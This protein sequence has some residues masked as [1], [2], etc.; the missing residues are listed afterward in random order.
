MRQALQLDR[1]SRSL[2]YGLIALGLGAWLGC[3][4]PRSIAPSGLAPVPADSARAWAAPLTPTRSLRYRLRWRF[5]NQKGSSGGRAAVRIAPP[6]TLR[7]DYRGPFGKSGSAVVIGDSLLW[8]EPAEDVDRLVGA[9][10]LFWAALGVPVQPSGPEHQVLGRRWSSHVAWRYVDGEEELDFIYTPRGGGRL[11]AELRRGGRI[12]GGTDV[13]F[14][15]DGTPTTA[16]MRFP[17]DASRFSFTVEA[18]DTVAAFDPDTW[19]RS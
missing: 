5:V 7:F 12:I 6:D 1:L 15:P 13:R 8:A 3:T 4:G 2:Y 14:A 11:Q 16:T 18:T 17:R 10:P 9:A 19:H